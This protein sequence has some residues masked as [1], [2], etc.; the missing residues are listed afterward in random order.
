MKQL[1][2]Y[3]DS[4]SWGIIPDTRQR[5]PFNKRWPGVLELALKQLGD[6]V[7]VIENCLN[8][9]RTV[10]DDPFKAGR[11]GTQGL[12]EQIEMHSPLALVLVMLGTNDFQSMHT[13]NAWHSAE[14]VRTLVNTIRTAHI[15]PGMPTPPVLI[16]APPTITSPQGLIAAKFQGAEIKSQ[17]L[18]ET[19]AKV[20]SE[21]QC[22]FFD[23]GSVVNSSE[24]DGIHL[25]EEDH[26]VLGGALAEAVFPLINK[27]H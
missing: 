23:A 16:I 7:R 10:W 1:L 27:T 26:Q 8:G 5:Q 9:R 22:P 25:D 24:V 6:D 17:G 13:N 19:L 11:N 4:L 14:G 20:A 15:E 21:I 2:V 12:A 3:S 18:T